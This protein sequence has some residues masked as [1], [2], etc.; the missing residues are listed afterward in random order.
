MDEKAIFSSTEPFTSET[1]P[2]GNETSDLPWPFRL[3]LLGHYRGF[4]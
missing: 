4:D 1:D 3:L 2:Q